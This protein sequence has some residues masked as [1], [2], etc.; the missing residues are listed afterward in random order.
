MLGFWVEGSSM[1]SKVRRRRFQAEVRDGSAV[2]KFVDPLLDERNSWIIREQV[3]QLAEETGQ[4]NLLLDFAKVKFLSSAALGALLHLNQKV[5]A[6]G[7]R[8]S[9]CHLDGPIAE[10]FRA[11]HVDQIIHVR[12]ADGDGSKDVTP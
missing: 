1:T 8:L 9:I 4:W 11:T 10:V 6:Q 3:V 5:E 12:S 2:V 7:G